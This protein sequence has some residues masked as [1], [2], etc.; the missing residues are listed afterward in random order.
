MV[1]RNIKSFP[2]R[3]YQASSSFEMCSFKGTR[4][5]LSAGMVVPKRAGQILKIAAFIECQHPA[6]AL[7][8]VQCA[9]CSSILTQVVDDRSD[10]YERANRNPRWKMSNWGGANE[11]QSSVRSRLLIRCAAHVLSLPP[12]TKTHLTL[13]GAGDG[14]KHSSMVPDSTLID[15]SW[16]QEAWNWRGDAEG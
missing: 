9:C 12:E 13:A 5:F 15:G 11:S 16:A 1:D 3:S 2:R 7:G 8:A 6:P 10:F 4:V 14:S